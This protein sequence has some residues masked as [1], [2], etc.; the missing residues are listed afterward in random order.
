MPEPTSA[1]RLSRSRVFI[2][3]AING[4]ISCTPRVNFFVNP[5]EMEQ[6]ITQLKVRLM[7]LK[8]GKRLRIGFTL[9]LLTGVLGGCANTGDLMSSL[10]P[11][12]QKYDVVYLKKTLI[13]GKTTKTQVTQLFGTPAEEHLD[14]SSKSNESSWTY[15][16]SEEGLDKYMA[17]AHKYVSTETS[18]KMYDASAQ[19]S[20]AQGV[21]NDVS[22]ATNTKKIQNQNQGSRLIIY[23]VDDV[24]DYYRLY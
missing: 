4:A 13:P 5:V 19:V 12:A 8:Y 6:F 15:S 21:A 22:S 10:N 11:G 16:K 23:F 18:L 7:C 24:V 17:L 9:C 1:V 2:R 3:T 20:K 14:S